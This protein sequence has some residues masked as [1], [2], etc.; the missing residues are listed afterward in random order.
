MS[1]RK[2]QCNITGTSYTFNPEYYLKKIE[3]Y[4][5]EESFKKYFITKKAKTYLNRGYSVQEVRNILNIE[6]SDL[7]DADS[8]VIR[9]L[10]EFHKVK[11]TSTT[12]R[13]A[14]TLNFATFKS[15]PDVIEFINN[16]R[17]YE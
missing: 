6:S 3:E 2:V 1:N 13:V 10:I 8:N 5:D 14:S 16:I 11:N 17:D 4:V 7:P 15:D 9:E 12:K